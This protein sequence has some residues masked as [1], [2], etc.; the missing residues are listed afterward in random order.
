[1][2]VVTKYGELGPNHNEII[3]FSGNLDEYNQWVK[4]GGIHKS[5]S[6]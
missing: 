3:V 1:M 6:K 5:I 4:D 2:C